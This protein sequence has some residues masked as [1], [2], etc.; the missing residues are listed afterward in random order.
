MNAASVLR[1]RFVSGSTVVAIGAYDAFSAR[2]VEQAGF[3]A[4]YIGSYATEAAML[5]KPDLALMSRTDRLATARHVAKAVSI[6]VIVDAEEGYGNA[7]SVMDTVREFERAGVAAIHL[8]D[9]A[10]PSKCPFLPG[11]PHNQLIETDEMCGKIEAA[12]AARENPDFM[13]IARSDVIG[14]VDR[15]TYYAENLLAEVVRRSNAYARAGADAIFVMA[16]TAAELDYYAAEIK[17]PL[18]GI[19]ATAEPLAITEFERRHYPLVIG[20]LVGIYAAGKGL[21]AAMQK[22]RETRDWNAIQD[23][24]INDAEFFDILGVDQYQKLYSQY[25]IR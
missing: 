1:Q 20:S 4:V 14:T 18:V 22:L 19:F 2:I 21:V 25:R 5:G 15:K 17:A 13:I 24:L 8:D 16:L 12:V 3:D 7:I 9:E 10:L 23:E 11:I 6:P